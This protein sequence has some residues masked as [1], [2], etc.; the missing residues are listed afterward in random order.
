MHLHSPITLLRLSG[1]TNVWRG[2][3][4]DD[5]KIGGANG[6]VKTCSQIRQ[7]LRLV[8]YECVL[9]GESWSNVT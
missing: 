4:A 7:N 1:Q 6:F 8:T 2:A 3:L 5:E 9:A